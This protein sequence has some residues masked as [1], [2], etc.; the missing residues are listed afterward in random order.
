MIMGCGDTTFAKRL[1]G[2][3]IQRNVHTMYDH[4]KYI[5]TKQDSMNSSEPQIL[6]SALLLRLLPCG[7]LRSLQP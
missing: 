3:V 4:L 6:P 2:S 7:A 5:H 1:S